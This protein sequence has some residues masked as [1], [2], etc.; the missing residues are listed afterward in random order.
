[1]QNSFRYPK[2]LHLYWDGSPLSFLNYLTVISFNRYHPHWNI[3]VYSPDVPTTALTWASHE[4]KKRYTGPC[5]LEKLKGIPNVTLQQVCLDALGFDSEASEVIK[6][7]YFRYH[8]LHKH[9]GVWSDFDI[10]Y[11][12]SIE[13]K[14]SFAEDAVVFRCKSTSYY[15]P[16]GFF[17]AMPNAPLFRYLMQQSTTHYDKHEYQSIGAQMWSTL[18]PTPDDLRAVQPSLK[19]CDHTYY[20]PWAWNE[21]PEFLQKTTN[22]LPPSNIGLHWFNGATASKQYAIELE[23]RRESFQPTCFLDQLIMKYIETCPTETETSLQK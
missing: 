3:I 23:T 1:M 2:L 12:A 14:M 19:I 11:T 6:S 15:Y 10:V 18:F 13:D 21:L 4:Q 17:I 5:Y 8:V 9:G 22:T 16:I 20:L 7:D